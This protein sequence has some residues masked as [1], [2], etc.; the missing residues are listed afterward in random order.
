MLYQPFIARSKLY[1]GRVDEIGSAA[2]DANGVNSRTGIDD[3]EDMTGA[4]GNP[5]DGQQ[6]TGIRK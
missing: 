5:L 4:A 2:D 6:F 1:P 3:E